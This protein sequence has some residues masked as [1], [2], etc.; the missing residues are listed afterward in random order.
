MNMVVS[1][2]AVALGLFLFSAPLQAARIWSGKRLERLTPAHREWF[3]RGYRALGVML[4]LAGVLF[5][6]DSIPGLSK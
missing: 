1:T 4:S 2:A 3:L 5:A 6:L